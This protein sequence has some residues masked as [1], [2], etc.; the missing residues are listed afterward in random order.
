MV[1]GSLGDLS[2][3]SALQLHCDPRLSHRACGIEMRIDAQSPDQRTLL[4]LVSGPSN[5]ATTAAGVCKG[6]RLCEDCLA[7]VHRSME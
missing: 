3:T 7:L 4:C 6:R 1:R 2:G 5:D